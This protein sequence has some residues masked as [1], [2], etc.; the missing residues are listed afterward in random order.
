[1]STKKPPSSGPITVETP[2]TA[3]KMPW[4]RPRSRGGMMSPTTAIVVVISPPAPSPCSARNAIS[5][6]MFCAIPQSMEPIRKMTI[7]T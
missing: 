7:A 5:S 3:P 4:Y 1:L 2:K 6:A